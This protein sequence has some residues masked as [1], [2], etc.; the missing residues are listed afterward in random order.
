MNCNYKKKKIIFNQQTFSVKTTRIPSYLLRRKG[1][2]R[3]GEKKNQAGLFQQE[4]GAH[5]QVRKKCQQKRDMKIRCK[6]SLRIPVLP[7]CFW[8]DAI[9]TDLETML[10][11]TNG[12]FNPF[13]TLHVIQ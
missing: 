4:G 3:E 1:R 5:F 13:N 6:V 12:T 10:N 11:F 2:E 8:N 9:I 7:G